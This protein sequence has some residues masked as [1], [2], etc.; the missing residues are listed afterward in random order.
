MDELSDPHT[1]FPVET[2]YYR[3]EITVKMNR[4]TAGNLREL[5]DEQPIKSRW[6]I[7]IRDRI[8]S[9]LAKPYRQYEE[10]EAATRAVQEQEFAAFRGAPIIVNNTVVPDDIHVQGDGVDIGRTAMFETLNDD[11]IERLKDLEFTNDVWEM[12]G[13]GPI[14]K[15]SD[16]VD[17]NDPDDIARAVYEMFPPEIDCVPFLSR[18]GYLGLFDFCRQV[19]SLVRSHLPEDQPHPAKGKVLLEISH[20]TAA[21]IKRMAEDRVERYP[22]RLPFTE[23]LIMEIEAALGEKS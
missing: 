15:H 20:H 22:F 13:N 9:E 14:E 4:G 17:G 18:G 11:L 5:L 23:A 8:K 1:A 16:P 2:T 6:A 3:N 19:V 10:L 12:Q 7:I 21:Y